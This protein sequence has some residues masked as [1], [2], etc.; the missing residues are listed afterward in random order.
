MGKKSKS[1][2]LKSSINKRE[3][4]AMLIDFLSAH[5]GEG[6]TLHKLFQS[7]K[8]SSHPLRMLCVDIIN[9]MLEDGTVVR[10]RN[11]EIT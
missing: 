3:L 10:K 5:S 4:S 11:A 1:G 9:E 7:L 2:L 6:Y 8:L